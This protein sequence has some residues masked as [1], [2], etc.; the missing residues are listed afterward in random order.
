M[1]KLEPHKFFIYCAL[2]FGMIFMML[3]PPFQSPDENSHFKKAY[4]ISNGD[5]YPISRDGNIGYEIPVE[6]ENYINDKLKMAG[7]KNNKYTFDEMTLDDLSEKDYSE[8]NLMDF[9]TIY[10]TPL[11]YIAPSLGILFAR[12]TTNIIGLNNI[13]AT[14]MLYFARFFSLMLYIIIIA[15]AIKITPILKK[16]FCFI[17]LIPMSLSL[18]SAVSYDNFLIPVCMLATAIIFKLIFDDNVKTISLK[19]LVTL[20]IIG[21]ILL[22]IKTVYITILFP[23]IFVPKSKYGENIKQIIKSI[24][25]ILVIALS[26]YILNK[27]PTIGVI[28]TSSTNAVNDQINF[29]ISQPFTYLRILW[30][31]LIQNRHFYFTS[32][33][34]VFGLLDTYVL[35]VFIVAY[36]I[37]FLLVIIS[38][39]SIADKKFN[40]KYKLLAFLGT[41]ASVFGIF[42]AMYIYWTSDNFD[43]GVGSNII[44]GVQGRYFLPLIP[45]VMVIFS[46]SW[47]Q[48]NEKVDS[49]LHGILNNTYIVSFCMLTVSSLAIL[50]RFWV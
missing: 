10:V 20:G 33:F 13:S 40:W 26:L 17:G 38:D 45:L 25:I 3:T 4:A 5:F 47:L 18:A 16:T 31:T 11:A 19:Y 29:V 15:K 49:I 1:F 36:A 22:S 14:N 42:L 9:S 35:T 48:K 21:F 6:M 7:N 30:D 32:L 12:I 43:G 34:G 27:I 23:L 46:N 44:N 37:A 39:L 8:K 50:L 28:R 41:C 24:G 2:I